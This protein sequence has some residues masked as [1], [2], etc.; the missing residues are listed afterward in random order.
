LGKAKIAKETRVAQHAENVDFWKGF[1]IGALFGL[2]AAA[3]ARGE[4]RHLLSVASCP[5]AEPP[6]PDHDFRDHSTA[7]K[8]R[9]EA[10]EAAGDPTQLSP[11]IA[12]MHSTTPQTVSIERPGGAP[13]PA[14]T[15]EIL[16]APGHPG[17]QIDH[18]DAAQRLQSAARTHDLT[19][20]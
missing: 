20:R 17:Q 16:E 7:L 5:D 12:P 8:L 1:V 15:P 10:S 18:S 9:R 11:A 6:V 3:Y 13:G 14:S 4:F 19:R 2:T